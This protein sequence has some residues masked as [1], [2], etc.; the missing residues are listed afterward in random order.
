M[1]HVA[2][3]EIDQ[4][5]HWVV[6]LKGG[7]VIEGT[8]NLAQTIELLEKYIWPQPYLKGPAYEQL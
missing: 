1:S 6:T 8:N 2:F 7:A 3:I 4:N 5:G